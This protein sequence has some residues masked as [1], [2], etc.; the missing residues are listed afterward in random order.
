[1]IR[2]TLFAVLSVPIAW[3]SRWSLRHPASH[4][5]SRFFAFEAVLAVILLNIPHWFRQP[6]RPQQLF[7]WIFLC[8]SLVY[9]AWGFLL[10]RRL[11]GFRPTA[12]VA[13]D[14]GW[15]KTGHLVTTGIYRRIRH[16]MYGSLF[17]LA[18]G[19]VLKAV[20][21]GS[22]ALGI[23]AS[24]ALFATAKAEEAENVRSFGE[25]YVEYMKRTNRFVPFLL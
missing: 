9:V 10:L 12:E 20:T 5:F 21:A 23:A 3:I 17:L 25:E 24:L 7:S 15:E 2:L 6:L 13:P 4:G 14:F 11:G 18:W 22:L 1:M 19:A 8:A 16:P